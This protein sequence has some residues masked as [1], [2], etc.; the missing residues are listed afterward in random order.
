MRKVCNV[1][2]EW[3]R[4]FP[5]WLK[6]DLSANWT[7]KPINREVW[8]MINS[9]NSGEERLASMGVDLDRS[10]YAWISDEEPPA[11]RHSRGKESNIIRQC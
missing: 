2:M 4:C 1:G 5:T 3:R 10:M 9:T 8:G 11:L 7:V 6:L